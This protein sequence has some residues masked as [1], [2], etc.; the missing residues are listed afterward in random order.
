MIPGVAS[1]KR[2]ADPRPQKPTATISPVRST[3]KGAS[4]TVNEDKRRV[5]QDRLAAY[6]LLPQ[7]LSPNPRHVAK[8]FSAEFSVDPLPKG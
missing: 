7:Q 6:G 2:F 3:G 8:D 4:L 1:S 5:Q